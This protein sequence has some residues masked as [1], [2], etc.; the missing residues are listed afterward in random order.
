MYGKLM[1]YFFDLNL[2]FL[3]FK[4]GKEEGAHDIE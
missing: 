1:I 4:E 3:D 2:V